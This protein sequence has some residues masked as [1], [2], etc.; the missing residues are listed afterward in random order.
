MKR[1][2]ARWTTA[3]AATALL[4]VPAAGGAQTEGRSPATGA[5]SAPTTGDRQTS[6]TESGGETGTP[7][8]PQEHLR[9]AGAALND[10]PAA[11]LTGTTQAQVAEMRRHISTLEASAAGG[12]SQ[13]HTEKVA[14]IDWILTE[15]LGAQ[16]TTGAAPRPAGVAGAVGTSGGA[17]LD[18]TARMKLQEVRRHVTAYVGAK[19]STDAGATPSADAAASSPTSA[20]A[21]PSAGSATADTSPRDPTPSPTG[22]SPTAT[23]QTAAPAQP[24]TAGTSETATGH[25]GAADARQQPGGDPNAEA[26]KRHLTAARDALSQIAQLPSAAQ[27]TGD[28]RVQVS[29]LISNFNELITT[30]SQWR[31]SYAKVDA[32]VEALLGPAGMASAASAPSSGAAVGTSGTADP[33]GTSGTADA[34]GTAGTTGAPGASSGNGIPA[35]IRGKLVEF[36]THLK[37]FEKAAGGGASTSPSGSGSATPSASSATAPSATGADVATRSSETDLATASGSTS[38]GSPAPSGSM[39]GSRASA[40]AGTS[41]QATSGAGAGTAAGGNSAG[42]AEATRHIEAIEA[43]LS[44]GAAGSGN[45]TGTGGAAGTA[46][47]A[48]T[49]G[50]ATG[51]AAAGNGQGLD[52]A[53][54]EQIRTHLNELRRV[55]GN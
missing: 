38:T 20:S 19:S 39:P 53:Q 3:V 17:T 12:A 28:T 46:G 14:E 34:T 37:E 23:P 47:T 11:S 44:R 35:D 31:A 15:L 6:G 25:T 33:T 51:S 48:G 54:I 16:S 22:T 40:A 7:A 27:L 29:Q 49:S 32:N 36:R 24:A 8:S 10:I 9:R 26:V 55:L 50:T 5:A 45:A 30:S 42:G 13:S 18:D 4:T 21:P 52:A 41:A 1:S 43:I 2:I